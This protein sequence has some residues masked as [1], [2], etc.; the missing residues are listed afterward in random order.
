MIGSGIYDCYENVELKAV[1]KEL[2]AEENKLIDLIKVL[3]ANE[4]KLIDPEI[5]DKNILLAS[6]GTTSYLAF[7]E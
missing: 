1:I 5:V 2:Q 7:L 3:Q 4:N 6:K